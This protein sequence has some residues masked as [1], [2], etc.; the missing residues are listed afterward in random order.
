MRRA[1]VIVIAAMLLVAVPLF[2]LLLW[3]MARPDPSLYGRV[4]SNP[5][6]GSSRSPARTIIS[7]STISLTIDGADWR[8]FV[9][10]VDKFAIEH[11][12]ADDMRA[13]TVPGSDLGIKW[14]FFTGRDADMSVNRKKVEVDVPTMEIEARFHGF[15]PG[16]AERLKNAFEHEVIRVG[17][18]SK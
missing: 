10:A 3:N 11:H 2:L 7:T 9:Q 8:R 12:L 17:R 6:A 18:F 5:L 14:F 16:A 15:S 1:V 4:T 13:L